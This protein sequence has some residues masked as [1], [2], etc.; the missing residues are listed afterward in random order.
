MSDTPT[1]STPPP[2]PPPRTDAPP[3]VKVEAAG[4]VL[5]ARLLVRMLD[6]SAVRALGRAIEDACWSLAPVTIEAVVID[7]SAVAIVPSLA[8][9]LLVRLGDQCQSRR[10]TL[11]LASLQPQVR[12]V[13]AITRLDSV[14]E[15]CA[16]VD[17]ARP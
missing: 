2:P 4:N 5:I 12:R 11:R 9:G 16:T 14:F 6:D 17:A 1:W 3:A 15:I 8:L 13:F 10:Q 7:M